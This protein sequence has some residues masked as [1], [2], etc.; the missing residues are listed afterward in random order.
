[1]KIQRNWFVATPMLLP[2]LFVVFSVAPALAS[3]PVGRDPTYSFNL[4]GPQT[5]KDPNTNQTIGLTGAGSFDQSTRTVVASGAFVILSSSGS[6]LSSG[7]WKATGFD[8]FCPRGGPSN[9][10]QGGVLVITVTLFP[11]EGEPVTGV[12]IT[13]ICLIGT[14]CNPGAEGVTVTGSV[15]SFADVLHG[16]TLFNLNQ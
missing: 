12:T 14:G 2:L 10:A 6:P 3:P 4:T 13:V 9:G 1:M 15:G 7:T 11:H 8:S 16:R 5:T